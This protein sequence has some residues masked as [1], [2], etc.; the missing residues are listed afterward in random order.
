MDQANVALMSEMDKLILRMP[1]NAQSYIAKLQQKGQV[2]TKDEPYFSRIRFEP[3]ITVDGSNNAT[4]TFQQGQSVFAFN[5]GVNGLMNNAGFN[6]AN[7]GYSQGTPADTNLTTSTGKVTNGADLVYIEG[8]S[9]IPTPGSD[10]VLTKL[11]IGD[12]AIAAGFNGDTSSYKLGSPLMWPGSAGLFGTAN[13][14]VQAPNASD[15]VGVFYGSVSNGLPG[16]GDVKWMKDP[17]VWM[18]QTEADSQF[19][20]QITL[21]RTKALTVNART[22]GTNNIPTAFTPP[23]TA[24]ADGTYVEFFVNLHGAQIGPRSNNR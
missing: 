7:T 14:K 16:A 4:Y 15:Q 2:V 6:A 9:F 23:A 3:T 12:L 21:T 5:Y 11:I 13:S 10:P 18:P 22:A 8:M 1:P 20:L 17:I 19:A 24:G